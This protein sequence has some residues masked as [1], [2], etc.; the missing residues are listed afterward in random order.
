MAGVGAGLRAR[1]DG[2]AGLRANRNG[3][4]MNSEKKSEYIVRGVCVREGML[5]LCRNVKVGNVYLPGGHIETGEGADAALRREIMEEMGLKGKAAHFLGAAENHFIQKGVEIFELNL[6]FELEIEGVDVRT[7]PR[8]IEGPLEFF[9]HPL[10][11]VAA[12]GLRPVALAL[13]LQ[14]WLDGADDDRF[15]PMDV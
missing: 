3:K 5:L 14:G 7:P 8:G 9:W 11:R 4:N 2:G 10:A 12:S 1:P 15:I 6:V 13:R